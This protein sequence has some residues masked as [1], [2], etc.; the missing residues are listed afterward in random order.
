VREFNIEF[1]ITLVVPS[2]CIHDVLVHNPEVAVVINPLE[3]CHCCLL[4]HEHFD[5]VKLEKLVA[6]ILFAVLIHDQETN[7]P[8]NAA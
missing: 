3:L 5:N 7:L 6:K 8:Q 2:K 4:L 1:A